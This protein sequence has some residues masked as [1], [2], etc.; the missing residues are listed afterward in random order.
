MKERI[1]V[2]MIDKEFVFQYRVPEQEFIAKLEEKRKAT[3][4]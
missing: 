1:P 4:S 2:I 3:T